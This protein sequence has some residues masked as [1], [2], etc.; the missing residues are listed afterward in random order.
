MDDMVKSLFLVEFNISY[1]KLVNV[2]FN[3]IWFIN[4]D[5]ADLINNPQS[6]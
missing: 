4:I 6:K 1:L 5:R 3:Y 2:A